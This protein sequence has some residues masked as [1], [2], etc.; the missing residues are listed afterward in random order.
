MREERRNEENPNHPHHSLTTSPHEGHELD[1]AHPPT[2]AARNRVSADWNEKRHFI[3]TETSH[4]CPGFHSALT[5]IFLRGDL[6]CL[7]WQQTAI[8]AV[9]ESLGSRRR[10]V[11]SVFKNAGFN[12]VCPVHSLC[13]S[14]VRPW[15]S[16]K[17]AIS[18]HRP[19][20]TPFFEGGSSFCQQ[21]VH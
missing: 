8:S 2:I 16:Q 18:L 10:P 13:G 7:S 14:R 5:S 1:D 19:A 11:P 17:N 15:P 20:Q 6:R 12:R 4:Q 21:F 3:M 9:H